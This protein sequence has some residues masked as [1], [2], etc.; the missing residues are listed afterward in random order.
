MLNSPRRAFWLVGSM[1]SLRLPPSEPPTT[2]PGGRVSA[3]FERECVE[4]F[5][6]VVQVIGVQRS[7][8][9][10]YGLLFASPDPLSFTDIVARLELSKGSASQGLQFL[11]SLGAV[12]NV[13]TD[14]DRRERFKPELGLR[15]LVGGL[16]RDKIEPVM[17]RGGAQLRRLRD[18]AERSPD[19]AGVK[20]S[21]G[22]VKQLETWRR[23]MWLLL[24]VLKTILGKGSA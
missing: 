19:S 7:V 15:R 14:G 20:F 16:L 22:R 8:G 10:I 13:G 23:Q 11:R 2:S 9:Q 5:V 17:D 6:E 21:L 4:F 24:P 18:A 1:K 3:E 12:Q